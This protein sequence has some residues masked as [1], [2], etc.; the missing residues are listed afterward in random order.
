[1]A[2]SYTASS[3]GWHVEDKLAELSLPAMRYLVVYDGRD[4]PVAFSSFM[5]TAE[6]D[7][8]GAQIPVLYC[9]EL[10]VAAE[11]R[12]K[13]LGRRLMRKL[14]AIAAQTRSPRARKVMLTCF[15]ANREALAF[16]ATL[17]YE[18]DEISPSGGEYEI[19][20]K[21]TQ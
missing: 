14:E 15:T 5:A 20:S 11:H 3:W 17:G 21:S 13:G 9:Y 16:Y 18:P 10:Q 19:L 12:H 7:A 1:M 2:R 4:R 8:S 6:E